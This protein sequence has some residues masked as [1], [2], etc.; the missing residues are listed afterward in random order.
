ML[1]WCHSTVVLMAQDG[2]P[3]IIPMLQIAEEQ[4]EGAKA[5]WPLSFEKISLAWDLLLFVC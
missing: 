2:A 5:K 3:A 4:K 1:I